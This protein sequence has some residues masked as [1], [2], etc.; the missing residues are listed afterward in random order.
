MWTT[1]LL[2]LIGMV[3]VY[4]ASAV[5]AGRMEGG[6]QIFLKRTVLRATLGFVAMAFAYF[7]DYRSY[8]R[9]ARK[10]ILLAV[11]LLV[12][13]LAFGESGRGMRASF[14]MMQPGEIAKLALVVYLADVLARRQEELADFKR[15]LL[16]RLGLVGAVVVLILLQP[17]FGSA[18]AVVVLSFVMLFLGG[19]RLLHIAGLAAAALP[20]A[21]LAVRKVPRI[22]ER[23]EVWRAAYDL[24][25]EGVD[26]RGAAYQIYQSLVALGSGG[27]TGVGVGKSMQRAFIPDPH[28]DF[29][30]SIWGEELGFLGAFG[31]VVLFTIL[32]LRGLRIA[33]RA[34]DLYGTIL[35]GGLTAMVSVYAIINIAVATATIP[36][37]GLPLP[38]V[39][40]GGSS[41]M[42]NL[43]AVGILLNMSKR[44]VLDA[45]GKSSPSDLAK[46]WSTSRSRTRK[47]S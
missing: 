16:P 7:V 29:A 5:I 1:L 30:F 20:V 41:L 17:D 11:V 45:G 22:A 8:R 34:P 25:L 4:T 31:L 33:R 23:W 43:V 15:G 26:T 39:S 3:T 46:R 18:L 13:T 37:T 6:S 14:L 38:F 10:G 21:Y 27:L 44:A 12:L 40:Y 24:S 9:Y 47:R 35:A 2:V 36:T 28:T 42:V 32:M 19:A